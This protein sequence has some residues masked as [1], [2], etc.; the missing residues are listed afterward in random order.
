MTLWQ[1]DLHRPP[2][3]SPSGE[4]L[5]ELLLCSEDFSFSYG[6]TTPQ[7]AVNQAWVKDQVTVAIDKAGAAPEAI[8]VF[9]PQALSLL[10]TGCAPLGIA[11][12]PS[13]RTPTLHQW[14]GQRAQW[15]PT[16]PNAIP[17]PYNPLHIEAPPPLPLPEMLWGD[18][19]GFTALSAADFEQTLP[20]E[21]IPIR[22]L[23][24]PLRP[25][26]LGLASTTPLPG[27]VIDAGRQALALAQWLQAQHPAWLSAIR[28]DPDGLIL[29]AG[30]CDRW[31]MTT[32][33]DPDVSTAG[34]RFEQRKQQ[35][36]GLHFLLV[37]PDDSGMTTT[38]LWL[39]QQGMP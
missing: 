29:E 35:S 38:G 7:S 2:L 1:A 12:E 19:W 22:Y 20:Y 39:L 26:R 6:A 8:R 16:Q 31:V 36:Q 21:P 17:V 27:I 11:V 10:T 9:R 32:F 33:S 23:P 30:L 14:L 13:R 3:A 4:P 5:W 28:G 18:R 37:R 34:Q 15:Y 24:P 25:A